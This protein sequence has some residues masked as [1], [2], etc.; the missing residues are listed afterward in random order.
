MQYNYGQGYTVGGGMGNL[1]AYTG[2]MG[3]INTM[4]QGIS[5]DQQAGQM[6]QEEAYLIALMRCLEL[7]QRLD[8][9]YHFDKR[10]TLGRTYIFQ[11]IPFTLPFY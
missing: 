11:L 8:L 2:L 6:M 1:G 3:N 5:P 10:Q 4:M 7:Y 9:L